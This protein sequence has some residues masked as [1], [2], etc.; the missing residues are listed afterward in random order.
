[1]K[2]IPTQGRLLRLKDIIGDPKAKPP[3]PAIVPVAAST[4][5]LGV[6]TGRFPK[7]HKKFGPRIT[8]WLEEDIIKLVH[9]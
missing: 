9:N 7:P 3:I 4:W 8:V 1:M 6:R 2:R 5:W